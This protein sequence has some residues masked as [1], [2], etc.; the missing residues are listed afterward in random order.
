MKFQSLVVLF[1]TAAT[2]VD[3]PLCG[4][5]PQ[6]CDDLTKQ[7]K[8]TCKKK[9]AS[10]NA[11]STLCL[12]PARTV[13][14]T[15]FEYPT[16]T[17]T[18]TLNPL[19]ITEKATVT[20]TKKG[21]VVTPPTVTL[22]ATESEL[23]HEIVFDTVYETD[24]ST[25]TETET[26]TQTDTQ[27]EFETESRTQTVDYVAPTCPPNN[28]A[29]VRRDGETLPK[30]CECYLTVT[31]GRAPD[32]TTTATVTKR[33]VKETVWEVNSV[34][35]TVTRTVTETSFTNSKTVVAPETTKTIT[36]TQTQTD[37]EPTSISTGVTETVT[38]IKT[39][40]ELATKTETETK[41]STATAAACANPSSWAQPGKI[42]IPTGT[43]ALKKDTITKAGGGAP[44]LQECCEL[45]F[46]TPNCDFFRTKNNNCELYSTKK[47]VAGSCTPA[48]CPFGFQQISTVPNTP[49]TWS[50]FRGPCFK[51]ALA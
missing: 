25:E 23:V 51:A 17:V 28:P 6:G 40:H 46:S 36:E 44:L 1:A 19:P 9:I 16:N 21:P 33:P 26:Q 31:S 4:D 45:C 39:V 49:D 15:E 14:R 30:Y 22:T 8:T 13:T 41:V 34:T 37:H 18:K 5:R 11:Q 27:T 29:R 24:Y 3:L 12:G 47:Q 7:D 48:Q 35:A 42:T 50:Y 2:A 10:L 20:I 38:E 43:T 32:Q